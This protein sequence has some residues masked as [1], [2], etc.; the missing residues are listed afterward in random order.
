VNAANAKKNAESKDDES[1]YDKDDAMGN[2]DGKQKRKGASGAAGSSG[3]N[4]GSGSTSKSEGKQG[5]GGGGSG[6]G[7]G[8]D[9]GGGAG[10]GA[11]A[12]SSNGAASGAAGA[13]G[14]KSRDKKGSSDDED[15]QETVYL[16]KNKFKQH[17]AGGV[18]G[19]SV[20]KPYVYHY[21][22][23]EFT[24]VDDVH[25]ARGRQGADSKPR[26]MFADFEDELERELY[27]EEFESSAGAKGGGASTED[28]EL[29]DENS[30]DETSQSLDPDLTDKEMDDVVLGYNYY[31]QGPPAGAQSNETAASSANVSSSTSNSKTATIAQNA[32]FRVRFHLSIACI[33]S[34]RAI[35]QCIPCCIL[36]SES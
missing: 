1:K 10:N 18:V 24:G 7:S 3:Q 35:T 33:S 22:S 36:L 16:K 23:Y 15:N 6:G 30:D 21:G 26:G 31:G 29:S 32:R 19:E 4:G 5:S 34:W 2:S 8:S 12:G 27:P 11:A 20:T 13:G 14:D 9:T 28:S 17:H 25:K